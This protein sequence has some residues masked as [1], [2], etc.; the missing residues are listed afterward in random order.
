[1]VVADA[2]VEARSNSSVVAVNA[3]VPVPLG[4]VTARDLGF[5]GD[6]R[7]RAPGGAALA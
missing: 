6:M 4:Q 5:G 3:P 7:D 1:M 2:G